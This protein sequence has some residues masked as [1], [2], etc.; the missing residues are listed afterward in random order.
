[1]KFALL[2]A[3]RGFFPS[4]VIQSAREEMKAAFAKAGVECLDMEVERTKYGAVETMQEGR[5]YAQF[6]K[7]HD[8]EYDGVVICLPNFGDENG[9]KEAIRDVQVPI[10]LQ[11][12][13]D[14]I[15][16]MD[17]ANRRDAFCGDIGL[18]FCLLV[19]IS[20]VLP[21]CFGARH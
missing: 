18:K 15:G 8:G 19:H 6:L 12:Y 3:N 4:T 14:E 9:I 16:K 17:F 2:V 7:E 1:M 20:S 5:I 10:L 11:A 13:P 21:C